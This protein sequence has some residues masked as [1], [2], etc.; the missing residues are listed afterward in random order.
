MMSPNN[1]HVAL[2][3]LQPESQTFVRASES[4]KNHEMQGILKIPGATNYGSPAAWAKLGEQHLV[5]GVLDGRTDSGGVAHVPHHARARSS[6]NISI[7][8]IREAIPRGNLNASA[9]VMW[10]SGSGYKAIT[11]R[12]FSSSSFFV[13]LLLCGPRLHTSASGR[14]ACYLLPLYASY[15]RTP[16]LFHNFMHLRIYPIMKIV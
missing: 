1:F 12:R 11:H 15:C 14:P 6:A 3:R 4:I 5:Q 2:D 16:F 13:L 10:A 7:S 9:R 8:S